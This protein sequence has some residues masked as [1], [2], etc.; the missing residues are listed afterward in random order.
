[1]KNIVKETFIT[2]SRNIE[3]YNFVN[4]LSADEKR[5]VAKAVSSAL[6]DSDFGLM[7]IELSNL[8]RVDILSL[9]EEFYINDSFVNDLDGVTIFI[10]D[11]RST[12]LITNCENHITVITKSSDLDFDLMLE[13]LGVIDDYLSD[14]LTFAFSKDYGY[15]SPNISILGTGMRA[16]VILHLAALS[17]N[18][19]LPKISSNLQK[20]GLLFKPLYGDNINVFSDMYLLT[21]TVTLG[22][23]EKIAASNIK[24][25]AEQL[26]GQEIK[27]REK[28]I[29]RI[30]VKDDIYRSL[31]ILQNAR[32]MSYREAMKLLSNL[33]LGISCGIIDK[34][35]DDIDKLI[36]DIQPVNIIKEKGEEALDDIDVK[37]ADIIR[38]TLT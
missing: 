31:G 4:V 30:D 15:L 3:K 23:E 10:S 1:M 38:K 20:L 24:G 25:I 16:S 17:K 11:D 26:C 19:F 5:E 35:A 36:F 14:K 12:A 7:E 34:N 13:K 27:S 6:N 33:R 22:I 29:E 28:L 8:E 18:N 37:R 9:F 32:I 2:I 21:N